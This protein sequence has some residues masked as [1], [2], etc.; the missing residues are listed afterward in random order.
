MT[1]KDTVECK[2]TKNME[3]L[4]RVGEVKKLGNRGG[5]RNNYHKIFEGKNPGRKKS[6]I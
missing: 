4:V 3:R 1:T 2:Y 6:D 5:W